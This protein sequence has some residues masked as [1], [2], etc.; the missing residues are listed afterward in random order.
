MRQERLNRLSD[1][2][3]GQKLAEPLLEE[4]LGEELL[5]EGHTLT[6]SDLKKLEQC[7]WESLRLDEAAELEDQIRKIARVWGDEINTLVEEMAREVDR[8]LK[9]DELPPGVIK[10]VVV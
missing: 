8:V 5:K 6:K 1:L 9:G 4:V 3:I 10:K 7:D 2:V